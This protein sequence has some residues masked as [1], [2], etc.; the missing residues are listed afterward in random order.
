M[1]IKK[2]SPCYEGRSKIWMETRVISIKFHLIQI[3]IKSR[4]Y[5]MVLEENDWRNIPREFRISLT[6][7]RIKHDRTCDCDYVNLCDY[8]TPSLS[9][10][11]ILY[12]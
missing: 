11:Y 5:D 6:F 9:N 3:R 1:V 2:F 10:F 7:R 12:I 8:K 4:M